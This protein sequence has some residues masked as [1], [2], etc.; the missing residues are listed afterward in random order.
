MFECMKEHENQL[1]VF[2]WDIMIHCAQ[3]TRVEQG[4]VKM[5][6]QKIWDFSCILFNVPTTFN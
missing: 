4:F 1:E 6:N 2:S 5:D 3:P